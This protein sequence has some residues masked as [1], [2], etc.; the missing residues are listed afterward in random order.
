[1]R[2]ADGGLEPDLCSDCDVHNVLNEIAPLILVSGPDFLSVFD[3]RQLD[4]MA[5]LFLRLHSE[6][7]NIASTFWGLWLFPFAMLVIRS[8]FIPR[9][10]GILM[11][12]AGAG[13]VVDSSTTILLPQYAHQVGHIAMILGLGELPIMFWLLIWGV[14][15]QSSGAPRLPDL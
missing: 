13:Y 5:F 7:I 9:V 3:K 15:V 2:G 14:R 12:I 8:G 10:L 4:S 1:M 11:M 6:G